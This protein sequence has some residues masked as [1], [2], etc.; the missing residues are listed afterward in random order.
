MDQAGPSYAPSDP[1]PGTFLGLALDI[2]SEKLLAPDIPDAMGLRALRPSAAIVKAMSIPDSRCI[3]VDYI[4]DDPKGMD[5]MA[6]RHRQAPDGSDVRQNWQ[7]DV[8]P[9]CRTVPCDTRDEWDVFDDAS[10]MEAVVADWS[11]HVHIVPGKGPDGA[12]PPPG[13]RMARICS[14]ELANGCDPCV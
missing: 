9:V 1:L 8:T 12:S 10:L 14:T 4:F 6:H 2:R 3:R 7:M 5:L 11:E 13:P